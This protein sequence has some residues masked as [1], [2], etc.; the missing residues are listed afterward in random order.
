MTNPRDDPDTIQGA[1]SGRP[2][3]RGAKLPAIT[4]DGQTFTYGQ[5]GWRAA[6]DDPTDNEGQLMDL[7]AH[8]GAWNAA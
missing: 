1:E 2:L 7:D 5:P 6:I 4:V 3:R 8:A